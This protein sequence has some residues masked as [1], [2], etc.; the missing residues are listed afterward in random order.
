MFHFESFFGVVCTVLR[1]QGEHAALQLLGLSAESRNG[2]TIQLIE[3]E[4]TLGEALAY[5]RA[6]MEFGRDAIA[7]EI[8]L[9]VMR[10]GLEPA[11][12]PFVVGVQ[13]V[14]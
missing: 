4:S 1:E 11:N 8:V 12:A 9:E 13:A 10:A 7:E 14:C 2:A 3:G 5:A 6:L